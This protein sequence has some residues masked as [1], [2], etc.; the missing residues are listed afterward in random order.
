MKKLF[1]FFAFICIT[2]TSRAQLNEIG[3]FFGGS[4]YI[5][6]IGSEYYINPSNFMGGVIFKRNI[7][8]RIALRGTFTYTTLSADD[9]KSTNSGRQTRGFY[10]N[11]NLKE[12]AAGLEF[13][14]FE[15]NLDSYNKIFTPYLIAEIA[16]FNYSVLE[17]SPPDIYATKTSIALPF[18][19]GVKTKLFQNIAIAFEVRARYTFVDDLDFKKS[20]PK[21]FTFGNPK[22]NDWYMLTGVS[23]VYAF[24]R[25]P[26]YSTP[27]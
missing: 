3:V 24:G 23:L 16:V 22:S 9:S 26:C 12:L 18:G 21:N 11:N 27:F 10:F 20:D 6:D 13:N 19:L 4:N 14:F 5:G 8:S 15:Y 25:P 17:S 1:L 2:G 7:N